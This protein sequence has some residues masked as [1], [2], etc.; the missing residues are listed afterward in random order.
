MKQDLLQR[1][2]QQYFKKY[3]KPT[4]TDATQKIKKMNQS[5]EDYK[6]RIQKLKISQQ[7]A[8]RLL[9]R[10]I[11]IDD[12]AIP[13]N[14]ASSRILFPIRQLKPS[15]IQNILK[16]QSV[17]QSKINQITNFLFE[18]YLSYNPIKFIETF[19][20]NEKKQLIHLRIIIQKFLIF[21]TNREFYDSIRIYNIIK[22]LESPIDWNGDIIPP[23]ST[24]EIEIV[25]HRLQYLILNENLSQIEKKTKQKKKYLMTELEYYPGFG[26]KFFSTQEH[27]TQLANIQKLQ[28]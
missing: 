26:K 9:G 28:S 2:K 27:F 4:Q 19:T 20:A 3:E 22:S 23:L 6:T 7:R 14:N 13:F 5:L 24:K 17:E 15:Q 25:L 16:N 10:C 8:G 21:R 12:Y 18:Q 11:N 1:L